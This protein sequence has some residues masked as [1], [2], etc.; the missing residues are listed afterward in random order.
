M[1]LELTPGVSLPS[2][3][4]VGK[5][6]PVEHCVLRDSQKGTWRFNAFLAR[7]SLF[8]LS[9]V[10][11]SIAR[12]V[13]VVDSLFPAFLGYWRSIELKRSRPAY[14]LLYGLNL[15]TVPFCAV[16]I[17]ILRFSEGCHSSK[18]IVSMNFRGSG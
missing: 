13:S 18:T 7:G 10:D 4:S 2:L 15:S 8:N 17:E 1:M 9:F 16:L 5:L 14:G 3:V 6:F 12:P 11:K